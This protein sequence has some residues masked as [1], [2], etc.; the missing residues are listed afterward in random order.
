MSE[1]D[2]EETVE[3]LAASIEDLLRMGIIKFDD[4]GVID[5]ERVILTTQFSFI[6]SK[7]MEDP[8]VMTENQEAILKALYFAFL[9]Y[10]DDEL[11]IPR[12]LTLALGNDIEKFQDASELSKSVRRYVLVLFNIMRKT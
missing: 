9:I 7:L 11:K 2:H 10:L 1:P 8:N 4:S 5:H 12:R 3:N 6:L